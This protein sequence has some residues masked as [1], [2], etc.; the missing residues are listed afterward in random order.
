MESN[1]KKRGLEKKNQLKGRERGKERGIGGQASKW[2]N[3]R[4]GKS[5]VTNER[6]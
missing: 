6:K 5:A 4:E 2:V 3:G 1:K